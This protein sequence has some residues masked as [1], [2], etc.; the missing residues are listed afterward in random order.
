MMWWQGWQ[1]FD[2]I[3]AR[4]RET[5]LWHNWWRLVAVSLVVIVALVLVVA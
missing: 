4:E 1:T 3:R 2:Q 5:W